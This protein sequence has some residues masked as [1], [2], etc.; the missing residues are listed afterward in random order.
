MDYILP[1]FPGGVVL[2]VLVDGVQ[3]IV[4]SKLP[5]WPSPWPSSSGA[6]VR[7]RVCAPAAVIGVFS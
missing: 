5:F 4:P 6:F 1:S 2:G 3:G 7:S